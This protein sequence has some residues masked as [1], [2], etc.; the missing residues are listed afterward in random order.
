MVQQSLAIYNLALSIC[1]P[2]LHAVSPSPFWY[3]CAH[4]DAESR[5]NPA[6]LA[7][8]QVFR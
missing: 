6:D 8:R 2:A 7:I 4:R 3:P 5:K 1:Q